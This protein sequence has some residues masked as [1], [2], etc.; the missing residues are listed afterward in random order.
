MRQFMMLAVFLA[1]A[2]AFA[3]S[4][5]GGLPISVSNPSVGTNNAAAPSSSTQVGYKDGNGRLQP[6]PGGPGGIAVTGTVST[7]I[8]GPLAVTQST[9]PWAINGPVTATQGTV[10]W[11]TSRTWNL[12]GSTDAVGVTGTVAATQGTSPWVTSRTWNLQ[13][14]TDAVGV[15]GTVT[16]N[17][18]TSPWVVTGTAT[19]VPQIATSSAISQ[20]SNSASSVVLVASN[21]LRKGLFLYNDSTVNCYVKFGTTASTSSFTLKMFATDT[22]IMDPPIYTGRIDYICDSASGTM[23]VSEL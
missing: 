19:S 22:Y 23:E 3:Q 18:G 5:S 4:Y 6:F 21:S 14:S 13:D 20:V 17:Q 16:A 8:A 11:S 9:V 10:P 15:T 1:A 12:Q 2:S 7:T